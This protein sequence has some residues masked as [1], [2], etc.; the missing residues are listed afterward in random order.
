MMEEVGDDTNGESTF[1]FVGDKTDE[2]LLH[3]GPSE[4]SP[5]PTLEQLTLSS[6]IDLNREETKA[7]FVTA[8]G[9]LPPPQPTPFFPTVPQGIENTITSSLYIPSRPIPSV[10]PESVYSTTSSSPILNPAVTTITQPVSAISIP[11]ATVDLPIDE[12]PA[13][14]LSSQEGNGMWG[15]LKSSDLLNKVAEKAK[16]SV[17]TMITTLDPGMKE[18]IY[19]GGDISI[20]VASDKEVKVSPIRE[21]FQHV[22]GRATVEGIAAQSYNIAAQPVGF[23]VALKAAEERISTLR[24]QGSIHEHQ[25]AVA[26]E[27]FLAELTPERWYDIGCLVL[28]DPRANITLHTYTQATPIPS[29]Y[30]LQ[31][32]DQTPPDY[33]LRWS[34]LAVTIGQVTSTVLGVSRTEWHQRLVGISRREMLLLAARSLAGMYKNYLN[35]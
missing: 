29:E 15:W 18:I 22:F 6:N 3:S 31:A 7:T 20:V 32:Q 8:L 24:Q 33:P 14:K 13:T 23:A 21:A 4:S 12:Y 27:N 9:N 2:N 25:P 35:R 19:S 17:D 34:G 1:E 26:I 10:L 16:N 28:H 30:I 11:T 5:I